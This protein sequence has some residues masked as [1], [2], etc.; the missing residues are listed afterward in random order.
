MSR[1]RSLSLMIAAA[2][3]VSFF[4]ACAQPQPAAPPDTRAAD[5]ATIR[6]ADAK[7]AK[8]AAAKDLEKAMADYADDAVFF[9]SG[10]PAAVGKDNIRKNIQGLLASPVQISITVA[11]VDVARSG[12]LA[13]DRGTVE[14]T[15][16]DKKGRSSTS[17]SD[18]VLV[19]KKMT[20]GSW[21]IEADTSA[22]E[23]APE[24]QVPKKSAR[25]KRR[26]R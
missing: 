6:A 16:T 4:A 17:T 24:R 18:Y 15:V 13:M 3:A 19:W 8:A 26:K 11:S 2:C 1:N 10:V 25:A 7:F 5:E 23:K 22:N 21:K 12:D 20:D 14:A 9:S